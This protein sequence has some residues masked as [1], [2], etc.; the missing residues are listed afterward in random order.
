MLLL[1]VADRH[2]VGLVE[3]DVGRHEDGVGEQP[4]AGVVGTLLL[5]LVLELRHAA[6]LAE[7]G[8]RGED[9][10]QLGVRAHVRLHVERRLRRLDAGGDVL[11][12]GAAGLL[13]QLG[14]ILR[15][16]ER[17]QVDDGEERVVLALHVAPLHERPDVVAGLER[18]GRWLHS[19][20]EALLSHPSILVAGTPPDLRGAAFSGS[21][22]PP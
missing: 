2:D 8:D 21:T 10:R 15:R 18:V 11:G 17:V 9:P 14:R 7:A 16:R 13:A 5:R 22:A 4:D 1:I 6:G 20:V 12:G 19:G 3:Q